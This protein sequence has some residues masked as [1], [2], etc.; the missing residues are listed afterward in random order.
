MFS[1]VKFIVVVVVVVVV[2]DGVSNILTLIKMRN[3]SLSKMNQFKSN[4]A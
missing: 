1:Y 3:Y 2:A 4:L